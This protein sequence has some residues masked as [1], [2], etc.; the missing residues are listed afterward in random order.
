[1]YS[2]YPWNKVLSG[3][4]YHTT[5]VPHGD[6][7]CTDAVRAASAYFRKVAHRK[8]RR[9][10]QTNGNCHCSPR[11]GS[12]KF[13]ENGTRWTALMHNMVSLRRWHLD[14]S[15]LNITVQSSGEIS[16]LSVVKDLSQCLKSNSDW[17]QGK[18]TFS[19]NLPSEI[20]IFLGFLSSSSFL[21][22]FPHLFNTVLLL[23]ISEPEL[24]LLC[25]LFSCYVVWLLFLLL[26]KFILIFLFEN[27]LRLLSPSLKKRQFYSLSALCSSL[28]SLLHLLK[29]P[30]WILD[31]PCTKTYIV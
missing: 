3:Q 12:Q 1:M 27:E 14:R 31:Y 7:C 4:T 6:G 20:W 19:T 21:R 16:G 8:G 26:L 25:L 5:A 18:G 17:S 24:R 15:T 23:F 28:V 11:C 30:F 9:Q 13:G 22:G 10:Q 2:R 29:Q